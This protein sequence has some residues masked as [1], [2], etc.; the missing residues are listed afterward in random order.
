[1]YSAV[2]NGGRCLDRAQWLRVHSALA[3]E[4]S[5]IPAPILDS[6]KLPVTSVP[7]GI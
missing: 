2:M 6:S 7:G 5:L 1:M 3:D 4:T